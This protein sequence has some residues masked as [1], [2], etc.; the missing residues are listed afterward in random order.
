[1]NG[2]SNNDKKSP[3]VY[4]AFP[5]MVSRQP[6]S[7]MQLEPTVLQSFLRCLPAARHQEPASFS[8]LENILES[9]SLMNCSRRRLP[10]QSQS[11]F[12][13][14]QRC[15]VELT[16]LWAVSP[17]TIGWPR[18]EPRPTRGKPTRSETSCRTNENRTDA[19]RRI[20]TDRRTS[21]MFWRKLKFRHHEVFAPKVCAK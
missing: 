11:F 13:R 1:M 19:D 16:F 12:A 10:S 7:G 14:T 6:C 15:G 21:K 17:N 5:N 20:G 8:A 18:P 2:I 3:Q 4:S 9:M